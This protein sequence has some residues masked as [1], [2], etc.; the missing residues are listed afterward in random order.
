MIPLAMRGVAALH[1]MHR[2]RNGCRKEAGPMGRLHR[3]TER[4]CANSMPL[5]TVI[6]A[7]GVAA[8]PHYKVSVGK[9]ET[10]EIKPHSLRRR[11]DGSTSLTIEM[12]DN[13]TAIEEMPF[14]LDR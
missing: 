14:G 6:P 4:Q 12:T 1:P 8:G 7:P 10:V 5:E 11:P 13:H 3:L 9:G 2:C